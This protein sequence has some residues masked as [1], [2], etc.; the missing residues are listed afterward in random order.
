MDRR[1]KNTNIGRAHERWLA[2]LLEMP[3]E[4]GLRTDLQDHEIEIEVKSSWN[5]KKRSAK[6]TIFDY[7]RTWQDPK[8]KSYFAFIYYSIKREVD[9]LNELTPKDFSNFERIVSHRDAWI[10]PWS[11]VDL[12]VASQGEN[13]DVY[14]YMTKRRL[15]PEKSFRLHE[16][17]GYRLYVPR[18]GAKILEERLSG[19]PF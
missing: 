12:L 17:E 16:G 5:T 9:C 7:Q 8:L 11:W 4:A 13:G 2:R 18:R 6:W 19:V 10:V 3:Y 15:P 1:A 14:C